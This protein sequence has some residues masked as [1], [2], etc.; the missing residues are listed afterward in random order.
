MVEDKHEH[1]VPESSRQILS[2][3]WSIKYWGCLHSISS[4]V[5]NGAAIEESND[6][7]SQDACYDL[8]DLRILDVAKRESQ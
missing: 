5:V 4:K 7:E 8:Q 2:D 6:E 1:S 3:V